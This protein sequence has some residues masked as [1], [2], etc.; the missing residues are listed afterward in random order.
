MKESLTYLE[1]KQKL[2]MIEKTLK[3]LQDQSTSPQQ[4]K[5]QKLHVLKET[6]MRKLRTIQEQEPGTVMT[7]NP[8]GSR[9]TC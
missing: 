6:Y 5:I 4:P 9:K 1:I 2:F 8:G 3:K 7:D